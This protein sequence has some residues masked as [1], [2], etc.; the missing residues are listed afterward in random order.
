MPG[1]KWLALSSDSGRTWDRPRPFGYVDGTPFYSPAAGSRLVRSSATGRL[2]W[3]GNILDANPDGNRPRHPLQIAEVDEAM[4]ALRRETVYA[5]DDCGPGDSPWLQL[6][7]FRVHEDRA[8]GELV[9]ILARLQQADERDHTSPAY[10]YRIR[11]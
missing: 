7:N 11:L 2:Y 8:T 10:E 4:P 3:I 6:S 1:R 5:I 9:V